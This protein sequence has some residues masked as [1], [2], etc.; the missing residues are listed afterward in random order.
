MVSTH[1][2]SWARV[3][4]AVRALFMWVLAMSALTAA[5]PTIDTLTPDTGISASDF[6]TK[7]ASPTVTG[8]ADVGTAVRLF[9]GPPA[10]ALSQIGSSVVASATGTWAI[11][12]TSV[13]DGRYDLEARATPVLGGAA[14]PSTKRVFVIDTSSAAPTGLAISPSLNCTPLRLAARSL[15]PSWPT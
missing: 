3:P 8:R 5:V 15:R 12:L 10:G 13:A 6:I 1:R 4:S 14:L 7:N 11:A 2:F 9:S